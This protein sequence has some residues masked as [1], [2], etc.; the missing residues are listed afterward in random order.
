MSWP[1]LRLVI[2]LAAGI[3]V[4]ALATLA[5]D[6]LGARRATGTALPSPCSS[7]SPTVAS[8]YLSDIALP[9]RQPA[10]QGVSR[11]R[12]RRICLRSWRRSRRSATSALSPGAVRHGDGSLDAAASTASAT[13]S[14]RG[15]RGTRGSTGPGAGHGFTLLT[16][17]T[18]GAHGAHRSMRCSL[19]TSPRGPFLAQFTLLTRLT[20]FTRTAIAITALAVGCAFTLLADL[21]IATAAVVVA[22]GTLADGLRDSSR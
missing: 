4:D 22:T 2:T 21:G 8:S 17:L 11:R 20:L 9:A 16:G 10:G 1:R 7:R 5:F 6:T 12:H 13:T 19:R 3:F 15:S 14:A 18:R